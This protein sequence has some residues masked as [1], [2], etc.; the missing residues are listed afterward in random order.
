M[1]SH[2]DQSDPLQELLAALRG[3]PQADEMA[4]E[5]LIVESMF[6]ALPS[7]EATNVKRLTSRASRIAVGIAASVLVVGG[8]AAAGGGNILP[9]SSNAPFEQAPPESRPP[10]EKQSTTSSSTSTTST[11]AVVEHAPSLGVE[12]S[13]T[14]LVD[15]PATAFD[16]TKCAEG[17]HGKTVSSVAQSVEPGPDH[18]SVVAEAAQSSCGKSAD[19]ADSDEVKSGDVDDSQPAKNGTTKSSD[20][21]RD[22]NGPPDHAQNERS[23][24]AKAEHEVDAGS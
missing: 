3:A 18:G 10:V 23:E 22:S 7:M 5:P 20:A 16:E 6:S 1:N 15:D 4:N 12:D 2:P 19:D 21:E 11:T 24:P 8:V 14:T 13:T 17:N 9:S